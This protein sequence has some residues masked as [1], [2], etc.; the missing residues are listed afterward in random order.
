MRKNLILTVIVF[1]T[2][3]PVFAQQ[4]PANTCGIVNIYDA[5]GNRTKRVY[6]CNLGIDPY[7]TKKADQ[8]AGVTEEFQ[9]VDALYPNP[10]TGKF[11]IEF[12]KELNNVDVYIIDVSGKMIKRSKGNGNKLDFDLSNVAAG[13]YFVRITDG[14]NVVTKKIIKQ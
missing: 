13:V 3:F 6:F 4:L 14:K 10:T 2:A 9:Y 1:I 5:T 12:S 7:P 11:F 8:Q